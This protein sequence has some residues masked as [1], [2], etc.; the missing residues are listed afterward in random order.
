[1]TLA[2]QILRAVSVSGPLDDDELGQRLHVARQ[3]VNQAARKLERRGLLQRYRG[4][5]GKLV[6][7]PVE[8]EDLHADAG[9]PVEQRDVI[10]RGP[11]LLQEAA[12]FLLVTCV[13]T[14]ADRPAAAKDLYQS[15][16]FRRQR[17]YAEQSGVPWFI[18][19]AEH[20][21]VAPD[22]WLAPYERYLPD[23]PRSFRAAWGQWVVER[24]KLLVGDL[25]GWTVEVHAS[26]DYAG[27]IRAPLDAAGAQMVEPLQ[28]LGFG[29][30][31]AWYDER[32]GRPVATD[33]PTLESLVQTLTDEGDSCDL[34]TFIERG[35]EGL[36][37]PGLYSWWADTAA[38]DH[39]SRG[40]GHAV[41]PGLIYAGLAG[42]TKWPSG[43]VSSNTLWSRITS[44][45]LGRRHSASTL[46]R[47]LG[48]ALAASF[49]WSTIDEARLTE[50]M[51][52]H[53]RVVAVPYD[54]PDTLGH[55]ETAVLEAIDPPL[56]LQ[57]MPRTPLR[58][59]LSR[60]RSIYSRTN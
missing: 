56:N 50:W 24:L 15:E 9:I 12:D 3:A 46:R 42:A 49:G 39:L 51:H 60:L 13:K 10:A 58:T 2:E 44:M 6:N 26:A 7:A 41:A 19:S 59:E 52:E 55:M 27:A 32:A 37:V 45:H 40:L 47:T 14:K 57:G 36:R 54:D 25:R 29:P 4:P 20:G 33:L 48:S 35:S 31:L 38:A 16:L 22:E 5:G 1:M 23:T 11:A 43:S 8:V 30:R 18:L 53:L 21:L 17:S 28:G 34:L